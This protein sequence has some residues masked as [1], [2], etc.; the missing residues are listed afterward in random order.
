MLVVFFF[1]VVVV[2][3]VVVVVTCD[4]KEAIETHGAHHIQGSGERSR[5]TPLIILGIID[6][7]CLNT[8]EE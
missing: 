8:S 7:N 5:E 3:V 1:L 6:F 2:V 4:V